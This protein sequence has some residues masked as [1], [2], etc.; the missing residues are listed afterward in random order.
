MLIKEEG[1]SLDYHV[2]LDD[3][4]L[5]ESPAQFT[6]HVPHPNSTIRTVIGGLE[7]GPS[8]DRQTHLSLCTVLDVVFYDISVTSPP[9]S[10]LLTPFTNTS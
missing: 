3:G 5:D 4:A 10:V 7:K 8:D 2:R 9:P 1:L 6:V